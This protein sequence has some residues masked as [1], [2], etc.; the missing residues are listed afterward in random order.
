L[1][2]VNK[3]FNGT[4]PKRKMHIELMPDAKPVHTRPYAVPHSL[5]EA[6]KKELDHLVSIG[7]LEKAGASNWAA[8]MFIIPKKDGRV[9]WVSNFR[10]LNHYIK[11]QTYPMPLIQDILSKRAGYKYFTKLDISMQYYTFE[12]ME[13][14]KDLCT[15][16]TPFGKYRY[17]RAPMGV[18]TTPDFAQ[19]V[20]EN[21][22]ADMAKVE[23]YIDDIG[24]FSNDWKQH[25]QSLA[26]ILTRLQDNGFTVNPLKCK[27]GVQETN[28]LGFWLT[29]VGLKP[30]KKKVDA[31]LHL[32]APR[33]VKDVLSFFG[34]VAYYRNLYPKHA[35]HLAPL[36]ELTKKDTMFKWTPEHQA[37]FDSVKALIAAETLCHY[38][39]H[40]KPFHVY[41]DASDYQ[42]GSVI[43][44]DDQPVAFFLKS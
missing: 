36:T 30:W 37:A 41:T 34:A 38:P 20:M 22:L 17:C 21:V 14:S 18:K 25:L 26:S 40:N 19:D 4:Y 10:A 29:P 6:F 28:W 43:K 8:R 12:L 31:I 23:V 3:D 39:N 2:A 44:Q 35:H 33:N 15:I 16:A 11:Q 32:Q 42:L 9:R 24:I 7:V 13:D 5:K 27:W 1:I